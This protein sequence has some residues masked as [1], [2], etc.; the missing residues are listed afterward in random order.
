M[1]S[2][3][4]IS[5]IPV[6]A[7]GT[8][9][10]GGQTGRR[11]PTGHRTECPA[12]LNSPSSGGA[13]QEPQRLRSRQTLRWSPTLR[14]W[15][16]PPLT[17]RTNRERAI[18][19]T[20]QAKRFANRPFAEMVQILSHTSL[21]VSWVCSQ[22]A[23]KMV[24]D[25]KAFPVYRGKVTGYIRLAEPPSAELLKGPP[26]QGQQ[27]CIWSRPKSDTD[28]PVRYYRHRL[29]GWDLEEYGAVLREELAEVMGS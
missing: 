20:R 7:A 10:P 23:M 26:P 24:E 21:F 14:R 29:S 1:R 4:V 28:P 27:E 22:E 12:K 19:P 15:C 16:L 5:A 13:G 9:N 25:G 2:Q 11:N 18:S 17:L 6:M 3:Q 8:G